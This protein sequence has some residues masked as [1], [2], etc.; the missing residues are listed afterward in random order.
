MEEDT[1]EDGERQAAQKDAAVISAEV[2]D[3]D[4]LR[5]RMRAALN[6][7]DDDDDGYDEAGDGE[8][9]IVTNQ[10]AQARHLSFPIDLHQ[11]S[12]LRGVKPRCAGV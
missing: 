11:I 2:S 7:D 5:S 9:G 12:V 8:D 1:D 3:M 10:D 4:Y 6:D